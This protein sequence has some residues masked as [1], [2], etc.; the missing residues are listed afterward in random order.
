MNTCIRLA[1]VFQFRPANVGGPQNLPLKSASWAKRAGRLIRLSAI[2]TFLDVL[3]RQIA[4]PASDRG[5]GSRT[6]AADPQEA[7]QARNEQHKT[8]Q[9]ARG[10]AVDT[11]RRIVVCARHP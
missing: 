2:H 9:S 7:V 8:R 5:H 1:A 3:S 6:G 10:H 11:S 4:A